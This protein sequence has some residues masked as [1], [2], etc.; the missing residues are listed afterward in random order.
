[1]TEKNEEANQNDKNSE[2]QEDVKKKRILRSS[3][4]GMLEHRM[5][6]S[7]MIIVYKFLH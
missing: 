4:G 3:Q 2:S 1:M 5:Q 6:L 7:S